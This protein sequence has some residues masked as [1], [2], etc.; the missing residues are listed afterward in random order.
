MTLAMGL[1]AR[2]RLDL[3]NATALVERLVLTLRASE[4]H[5]LAL[6]TIGEVA[7]VVTTHRLRLA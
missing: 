4:P 6:V 3:T 7:Y 1:T 5:Q 2:R